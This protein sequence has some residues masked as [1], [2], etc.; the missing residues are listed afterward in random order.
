MVDTLGTPCLQVSLGFHPTFQA[1]PVPTARLMP[2]LP[3]RPACSLVN[4]HV[5]QL[6]QVVPF[7]PIDHHPLRH[8]V[9]I[10]GINCE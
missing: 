6:L 4:A 3:P 10:C 7:A 9:V 8:E 5:T 2:H 1:G